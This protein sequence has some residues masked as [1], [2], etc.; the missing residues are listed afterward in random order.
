MNKLI[1]S[2]E[3]VLSLIIKICRWLKDRLYKLEIFEE[4][5]K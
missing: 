2:I 3:D 1:E 4:D 5:K